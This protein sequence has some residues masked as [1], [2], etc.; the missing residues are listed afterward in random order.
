MGLEGGEGVERL[1]LFK[2]F[3]FMYGG[4]GVRGWGRE[5]SDL[6]HGCGWGS[7]PRV[8]MAKYI[9]IY[10]YDD[11]L[12]LTPCLF[13]SIRSRQ[14]MFLWCFVVLAEVWRKLAEASSSCVKRKL[15][16]SFAEGCWQKVLLLRLLLLS[17]SL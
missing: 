7:A 8:L 2:V 4:G 5:R 3:Y 12:I 17:L 9:Y 13:F 10:I 1:N 11:D 16:G 14:I 6:R 15:G